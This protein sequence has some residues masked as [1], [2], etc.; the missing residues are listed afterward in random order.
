MQKGQKYC[1]L[2]TYEICLFAMKKAEIKAIGEYLKDF[3]KLKKI[4]KMKRCARCK[5]Q[6]T[7]SEF[8]KKRQSKDGLKSWCKK[9]ECEY[10]CERYRRNR[11]DVKKYYVYEQSHRVVGGV[12][13]KRCRKC[14]KWK[15]ES[16]FYKQS[17]HKDG[18]A[19][20]CKECANKDTNK[21]RE[22]RL[23]VR[24]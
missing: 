13:E 12:K 11:G 20:R 19:N 10:G 24:N 8:G 5:E 4:G 3:E 2:G 1:L 22:R 6:Q 7:E 15:A 23:A 21:S 16:R 9:C 17:K 18:L 14:R